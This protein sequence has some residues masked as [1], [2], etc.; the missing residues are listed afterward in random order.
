[1]LSI[2]C[3]YDA[4]MSGRETIRVIV[5]VGEPLP[6]PIPG[7]RHVRVWRWCTVV[8]DDHVRARVDRWFHWP[9]IVLAL[10]VLPLLAIELL[11]LDTA[12]EQERTW[13][14]VLC[15]VGFGLIWLAFVIE[16]VVK[17]AI[18]ESRMEYVRR[19]WLDIV[20]IVVPALRPLRATA[21]VRTSRVFKLRGVGMK[22]FRYAFAFVVGL[23]ATDHFLQKLGLKRRKGLPEPENMTRYE[24]MDEVKRLRRLADAWEAW[25]QAEREFLEQQNRGGLDAPPPTAG[26]G[27]LCDG[28]PTDRDGLPYNSS[29]ANRPGAAQPDHR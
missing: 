13:L 3:F 21:V 22:L 11:Y 26:D 2:H 19:N 29:D 4:R 9:M 10:A 1:M 14:E 8:A 5:P 20:I 12:S 23:D 28:V 16:F 17:I 18:A 15:W 25:H 7:V 27:A 24:L 6:P